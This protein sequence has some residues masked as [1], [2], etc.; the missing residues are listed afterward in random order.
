MKE[1][2]VSKKFI[3]ASKWA[4]ITE[5]ATRLASPVTNMVLARLITPQAF[6]VVATVTMIITFADMLTDAGFQKYLVQHEFLN[7]EEKFK[8]ANVAFWT[9]FCISVFLWIIIIIFSE[10]ISVLVGNRGLGKVIAVACFQLLL[11]SFSSIQMSLYKRDFDFK[12]LFKVKIGAVLIPFIVTVP[13]AFIGLSYWA[14]IIGSIVIQFYNAVIL[15]IKSTWKPY[16]F[17]STQI[18]KKMLSFSL[19]SL[20]ESISIWLTSWVDVF[21]ISNV[22]NQYYLG[23]YKTSTMMVNAIMSLVTA[24]IVPVLFSALSR[25]QE[26]DD[27][28]RDMYFSVQKTVSIFI[29]PLGVGVFVFRDLA[30]RIVLGNKWLESSA[31]IG[32]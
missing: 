4:V 25:L 5:I 27:K 3:S 8:N 13:L 2:H 28:F 22:L 15:T 26:D 23:I 14:L 7:D 9:N 10:K 32:I 11:T 30:T 12:T 1:D 31:I 6:G 17:Y 16:F 24:S 18:L 19:W 29:L 21:I 20:I